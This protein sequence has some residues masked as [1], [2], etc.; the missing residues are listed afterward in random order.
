MK[1]WTFLIGVLTTGQTLL[2]QSADGNNGA[3]VKVA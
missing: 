3:P 1:K 2:A